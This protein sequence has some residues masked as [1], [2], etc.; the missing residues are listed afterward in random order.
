MKR[1]DTRAF[2]FLLFA[3][4]SAWATLTAAAERELISAL[5]TSARCR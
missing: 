3:A 5:P 1:T 4:L 2:P